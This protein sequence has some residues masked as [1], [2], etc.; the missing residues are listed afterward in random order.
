[1]EGT[2][3][4]KVGNKVSAATEAIGKTLPRGG[5]RRNSAQMNGNN[6]SLNEMKKG[7]SNNQYRVNETKSNYTRQSLKM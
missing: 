1:M 3:I 2:A 6:N 7:E 5:S 4:T